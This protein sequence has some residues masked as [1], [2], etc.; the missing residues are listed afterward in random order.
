[1]AVKR[2]TDGSMASEAR[3]TLSVL[4]KCVERLGGVK[5]NQLQGGL[6]L[7]L[8]QIVLK[9]DRVHPSEHVFAAVCLGAWITSMSSAE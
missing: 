9:A 6:S 5:S 1:M 7:L 2:A 4:N 8:R 3:I